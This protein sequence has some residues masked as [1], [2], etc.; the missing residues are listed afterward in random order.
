MRSAEYA[1]NAALAQ[2][3]AL[4]VGAV[5]G[6]LVAGR[7][8]DKI[9]TRRATV[10]WFISAALFL[11]LLSIPL[12]GITV[13][14]GVLLA[15][16]FVFSSQ[17]LVYA[18]ISQLYPAAARGT[19]VGTASGVGRLG[20]IAGQL[21][22]GALLSAGLA[23]P[24]GFYVFA[25]V[26]ALGALAVRG[27]GRTVPLAERNRWDECLAVTG[28]GR[29]EAGLLDQVVARADR[30]RAGARPA[31]RLLTAGRPG[32]YRLPEPTFRVS[33][34]NPSCPPQCVIAPSSKT[35]STAEYRPRRRS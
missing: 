2:L 18:F 20:A 35:I 13:Y 28:G 8:A 33:E 17:V 34:G 25:A 11:A 12:P 26:A 14:G 5:L 7:V 21:I 16:V 9:G 3:L 15:G 1:L 4:N 10:A 29:P 32:T 6:L 30:R 19:A 24:W 23:Y 27:R 31:S 22:G